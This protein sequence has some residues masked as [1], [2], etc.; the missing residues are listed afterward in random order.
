MIQ[1]EKKRERLAA[2]YVNK[3]ESL[4]EKLTNVESFEERLVLYKK[5]E[6]IPKG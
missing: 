2:K 6:Q 4:K 1:R 3:R 5:F